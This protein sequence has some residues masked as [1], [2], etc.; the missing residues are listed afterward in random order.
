LVVDPRLEGDVMATSDGEQDAT[1]GGGITNVFVLMLENHS[2]D[3]VFAMSG[4]EGIRAATTA[5]SNTWRAPG[6]GEKHTSHVTDDAPWTMTTDPGHEFE[7]VLEQLSGVLVCCLPGTDPQNSKVRCS[8][9]SDCYRGGP[10]PAIDMSGFAT[11]YAN[12]ES[13]GTGRPDPAHVPDIMACFDTARDL[14]VIHQLATE[15]AICDAWFS[16]MPGPTW[17]N[18]FFVHG[19]SSAG[20][21]QSPHAGDE[22]VWETI[23][24]FEYA[25]GS[26]FHHL[27]A[28][29]HDWR[30]YQD[31]HNDFSD[32]PSPWHQGGWISQVAALKGVSLLD[33][34]D[35][36]RFR[37]DLHRVDDQGRPAYL[38]IPYTFIE[39]N[40]GASFLAKQGGAPGP[41]Y[42]GGSAQHPE[43]DPTG[44][45][46]LVKAVYEAIRN[47]PVW[48]TSVLIV[49]YDEHG[50]FYDSVPP[51]PAPPPGDR[52]PKGH[53]KLN[54]FGFDFAT[55]GV[56]VPAVVVSPRI[57]RGTVDHTLYDHTSV[58]ATVERLLGVDP[59]TERDAAANDVRHLLSLPESRTECPTELV[60]PARRPKVAAPTPE[61]DAGHAPESQHDAPL[62][63][64]SNA[65]GFLHV[66]VK[67]ELEAAGDDP[68]AHAAVEE[69]LRGVRTMGDAV[70]LVRSLGAKFGLGP[71]P[72]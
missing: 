6:G 52:V 23:H 4:I 71:G 46:G 41:T 29:G 32:D 62:P 5:D 25:N 54:Q 11:N 47:S 35:F 40:F 7:D 37:D 8:E 15:F 26:I 48:D 51:G 66:L 12:S 28:A 13:E 68:A 36:R 2:F 58:L 70:D 20:V 22:V 64:N 55:Y 38:D 61:P 24:G 72:A 10:Y 59:L 16:S 1:A 3:N 17:P 45:E 33:V 31:K 67:A 42:K 21:A 18:R 14:P 57:P 27:T 44:G 69:R 50:G 60:P 30:L 49:V 9:A 63:T 43:D 56:R 39:P 53:D 65:A 34:R 19:A